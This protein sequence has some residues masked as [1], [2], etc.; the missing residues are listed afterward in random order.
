M[1]SAQMNNLNLIYKDN[2][3]WSYKCLG[4]QITF[5]CSYLFNAT[6]LLVVI[7]NCILF[8]LKILVV[9]RA[10]L[11]LNSNWMCWSVNKLFFMCVA[12]ERQYQ[13]RSWG[14]ITFK[15]LKDEPCTCTSVWFLSQTESWDVYSQLVRSLSGE[16]HGLNEKGYTVKGRGLEGKGN[17]AW[18][19]TWRNT[20]KWFAL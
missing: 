5:Y 2:I 12:I 18:M 16:G 3:L 14:G 1:D 17:V 15:L 20:C 10:A 6:F 9:Q 8:F 19:N 11:D 7:A 4:M 13:A